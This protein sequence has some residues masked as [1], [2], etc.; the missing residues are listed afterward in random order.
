MDEDIKMPIP[1][2][3]LYNANNTGTDNTDIH[4][5]ERYNTHSTGLNNHDYY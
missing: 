2:P 4:T 5:S 3:P 1:I